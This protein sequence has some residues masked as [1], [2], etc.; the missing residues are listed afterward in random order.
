MM[1]IRQEWTHDKCPLCL[2]DNETNE[3]VLLCQDPRALKHWETLAA[4]LDSDMQNMT[5]ATTI[6]R[7]IM[8]K[9]H[10]WR[11]RQPTAMNLTNEYGERDAALAQ[12]RIGWTNFMLG[13]MASKWAAAQQVYLDHLGRRKTGK[14]WLIVITAKL[15]KISWDMW[16]NSIGILHHNYH[17]WKQLENDKAN[18]LIDE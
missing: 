17:P 3:H 12:D 16:D 5:T 18:K 4:K 13:R 14:C 8:R 10:N 2:N 6:R 7:T 11:K 9:L 15:L 1:K